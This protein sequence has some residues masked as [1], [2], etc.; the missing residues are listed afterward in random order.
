[1]APHFKQ[2]ESP[3][4]NRRSPGPSRQIRTEC[5]TPRSSGCPQT[6]PDPH[7]RTYRQT[8]PNSLLKPEESGRSGKEPVLLA[9]RQGIWEAWPRVLAWAVGKNDPNPPLRAGAYPDWVIAEVS[10]FSRPRDQQARSAPG[11]VSAQWLQPETCTGWVDVTALR[12]KRKAGKRTFPLTGR[13]RMR[14]LGFV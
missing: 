10:W 6:L 3:G 8:R 7:A 1:V 2:A 5:L 11:S 12:Q 13:A 9:V 4:R 14:K